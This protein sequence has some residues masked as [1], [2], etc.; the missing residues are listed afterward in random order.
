MCM[1]GLKPEIAAAVKIFESDTLRAVFRLA[2]HK[3][4]EL[5]SWRNVIGRY[6][7]SGGGGHA[8]VGSSGNGSTTITVSGGASAPPG[9]VAPAAWLGPRTLP[10]GFVRLSLAEI[11]QKRREGK[12][13]N[14]DER[15]TIGHKCAKPDLMMLVGRWEDEAEEDAA[16][17]RGEDRVE[18]WQP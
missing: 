2:G 9:A 10:K 3:E 17:G 11:D 14:C 15:F 18:D 6:P 16:E 8:G 4:E 5:A 13:F 1:A 12:C 7:K